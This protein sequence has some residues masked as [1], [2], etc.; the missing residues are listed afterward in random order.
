MAAPRSPEIFFREKIFIRQTGDTIIAQLD[1]GNVANNTLH[2]IF[3]KEETCSN[4]Y[5]LGLLNSTFMT[6]YYQQTH[7]LEVG[8]PMAEVKKNFVEDLPLVFGNE[9]QQ[10]QI[11]EVTTELLSECKKRHGI[12]NKF[13]KYIQKAFEPKSIS[14]RIM[15]FDFLSYK[16]FCAELKKQK[17]KLSS[18]EQ[19]DLLPVYEDSVKMVMTVSNEIR[20]LYQ[21]LDEI[22]FDI[23]GLDMLTIQ[24]IQ[25]EIQ[26]DI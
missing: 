4:L 15:N 21:R 8:K 2:V 18:A 5:L 24:R 23:Y 20:K 3:S 19:M 10:K 12:R 9:D 7:P 13:V 11:I 16:E 25:N 26:I 17:V 14:E 22:V 1:D 6:W